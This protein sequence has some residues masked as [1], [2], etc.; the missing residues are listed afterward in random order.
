[1]KTWPM[2]LKGITNHLS[3]H[4]FQDVS[5]LDPKQSL[6]RKY[7]SAEIRCQ[8]LEEE[9]AQLK[10]ELDQNRSQVSDEMFCV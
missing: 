9:K 10:A 7:E 4:L 5:Y 2:L 8:R 1:M 6:E 3:K